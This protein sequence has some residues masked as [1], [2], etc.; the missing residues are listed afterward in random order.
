MNQPGVVW[1]MT[2]SEEEMLGWANLYRNLYN[3]TS[4]IDFAIV[5]SEFIDDLILIKSMY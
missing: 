1:S 4:N 5:A 2:E 3:E